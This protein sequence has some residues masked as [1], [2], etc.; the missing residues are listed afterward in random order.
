MGGLANSPYSQPTLPPEIARVL[1]AEIV[2]KGDDGTRISVELAVPDLS[3]AE[4]TLDLVVPAGQLMVLRYVQRPG[5]ALA[6]ERVEIVGDPRRIPRGRI[7]YDAPEPIPGRRRK[8]LGLLPL[9]IARAAQMEKYRAHHEGSIGRGKLGM[10]RPPKLVGESG[11]PEGRPLTIDGLTVRRLTTP[12]AQMLAGLALR[13]Q[14]IL[15]GVIEVASLD[16]IQRI[17]SPGTARER[18]PQLYYG[19]E[20]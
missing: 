19:Y 15:D 6:D 12:R 9:D 7:V 13:R 5:D 3:P 14:A 11:E 18:I 1:S 16:Y 4:R 20:D 10:Y 2:P 17:C 8:R